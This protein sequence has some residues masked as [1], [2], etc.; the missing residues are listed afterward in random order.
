M[1]KTIYE[2]DPISYNVDEETGE[3]SVILKYQNKEYTG[4][5]HARPEDMILFSEKVGL[6]IAL[7][8]ARI[9]IFKDKY[10]EA[11]QIATIKNQMYQETIDFGH[12]DTAEVDPTG[13]FLSKV[14]NAQKRALAL[15]QALIIERESLNTYLQGLRQVFTTI[16]AKRAQED[17]KE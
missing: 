3:C 8:R 14:V 11:Q 7:R 12:R 10:L 4:I 17:K 1:I 2:L 9:A 15:K 13:A 5:A 6:N 16:K